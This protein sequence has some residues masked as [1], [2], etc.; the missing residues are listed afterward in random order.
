[1]VSAVLIGVSP[2][3]SFSKVIIG[4]TYSLFI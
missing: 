1:M 4:N 2:I 3:H